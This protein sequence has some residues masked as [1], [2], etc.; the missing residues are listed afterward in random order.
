[1]FLDFLK[2][3]IDIFNMLLRR[4]DFAGFLRSGYEKYRKIRRHYREQRHTGKY[5]YRCKNAPLYA[6]GYDVAI[7]DAGNG[8]DCPPDAVTGAFY[9]RINTC[10]DVTG[11]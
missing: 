5:Q 4:F 1:M 3:P 7:A 11:N 6:R 8:Y 2:A 9:V 10:N